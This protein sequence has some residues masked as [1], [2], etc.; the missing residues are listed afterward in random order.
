MSPPD[1]NFFPPFD[2]SFPFAPSHTES[3]DSPV[4]LGGG[5][6]ASALGEDKTNT[7][8]LFHN[9]LRSAPSRYPDQY[10]PSHG[11]PVQLSSL[12]FPSAWESS[13]LSGFVPYGRG[14]IM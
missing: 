14:D 13:L 11:S 5:L 12:P 10:S 8:S 3:G 6:L 4:Y 7:Q 9:D 2:A 1:M